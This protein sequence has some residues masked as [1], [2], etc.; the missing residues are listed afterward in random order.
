[1]ERGLWLSRSGDW[2]LHRKGAADARRHAEKLKEALKEA[3]PGAVAEEAVVAQRGAKTVKV[4]IRSLELPRLRYDYGRNK[5]VGQGAGGSRPGDQAGQ[6][7]RA[8]DGPGVDYV[9]AEIAIDDLAALVFE[10][11]ELPNLTQKQA[12]VVESSVDVFRE[13]ARRG[14]MPNLDKRRTV[15]QNIKRNALEGRPPRFGGV[16]LDDLRFRVWTP[17]V[18]R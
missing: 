6:G 4:P 11:F 17:E 16:N 5:H 9:E 13:I 18:K 2:A 1:M 10:D 12:D 3:L 15:L 14:V 7:R 8:G